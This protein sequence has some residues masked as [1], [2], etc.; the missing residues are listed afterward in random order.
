M[1]PLRCGGRGGDQER[2]SARE[3]T[4]DKKF[5]GGPLGSKI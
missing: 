2:L 1:T 3:V 5:K 4:D